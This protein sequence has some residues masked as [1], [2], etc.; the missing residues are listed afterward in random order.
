MSDRKRA[1]LF[2][3]I[4]ATCLLLIG[5][6]G[7]ASAVTVT[8]V[9]GSISC[10]SV[11]SRNDSQARRDGDTHDLTNIRLGVP[12]SALSDSSL[13]NAQA[14]ADGI[15]GRRSWSLTL[16]GLGLVGL[17]GAAIFRRPPQDGSADERAAPA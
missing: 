12:L 14:C 15:S 3:S 9:T 6:I 4:V 2:V 1:A 8:G 7:V 13:A 10:G 5:G 17:L 11:W 16:V